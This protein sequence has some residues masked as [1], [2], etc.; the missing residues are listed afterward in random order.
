[1][2]GRKVTTLLEGSDCIVL[3]GGRTLLEVDRVG[4][5]IRSLAVGACEVIPRTVP[6]WR[7][8]WAS[9]AT[10]AP[11]PNRLRAGQWHLDGLLLRGDD[12]EGHG[13]ALHGL[14][15]NRRFTVAVQTESEVTLTCTLG[16]D[17]AY[18][19]PLSVS[20]T[21]ELEQGGFRSTL[22]CWNGANRRLPVAIGAHP[23]FPAPPGTELMLHAEWACETDADRIPTGARITV[24]ALGLQSHRFVSIAGLCLDDCFTAL[25]R[26]SDGR[27]HTRL[28]Y[29]DARVVDIWQSE[30]FGYVTVFSANE[31]PWESGEGLAIAVEPQSAPANALQ[32]GDGLQWLEPGERWSAAWGCRL[33]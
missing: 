29:A 26:S 9:G 3:R 7:A 10:L 2:T 11:W 6:A 24:D 14:V 31:Y 1:M 13:H 8:K 25:R 28:Q 23:Y 30:G 15:A 20:V 12:A 17:G 33:D 21:Y 5:A 19:F 18:P 4:A 32:S 22:E 16:T 27:A